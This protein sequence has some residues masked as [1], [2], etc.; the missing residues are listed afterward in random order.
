MGA[1]A[2]RAETLTLSNA[3]CQIFGG[4]GGNGGAAS[5]GN[6]YFLNNKTGGD[7]GDGGRGGNALTFTTLQLQSGDLQTQGGDGGNGGMRGGIHDGEFGSAGAQGAGGTAGVG[8]AAGTLSADTDASFT[9]VSGTNGAAGIGT[10]Q[11]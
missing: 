5:E 3:S 10:N 7:G 4:N 9:N 11:D 2:V 8:I 6:G 1:D